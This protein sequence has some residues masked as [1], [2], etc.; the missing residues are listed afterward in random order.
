MSLGLPG[1]LA[2][3]SVA[4]AFARSAHTAAMTCVAMAIVAVLGY[5][6]DEPTM[7][8]WPSI[9]ALLPIIAML[10]V[11]ALTP[12]VLA[13][14]AYLIVGAASLGW[15]AFLIFE[16]FAEADASNQFLITTPKIALV[17]VMGP[18][19]RA[20]GIL[21]WTFAGYAAA[22]LATGLAANAAGVRYEFDGS[23][24]TI[25]VIL[26]IFVA[27]VNVLRDRSRQAQ[28]VLHRAAQE[29]S[30]DVHRSR[31]EVL[32]AA[33][34][35]D[36]V[37]NDLAAIAAS[38]TAP[39][40]PELR[41]QIERDLQTLFGEEWLSDA[42]DS[43]VGGSAAGP[44]DGVFDEARALGLTLIVTG[45]TDAL[46]R[47][48]PEAADALALAVK[49]CLVNVLKHSG[50]TDAE[51]VVL[52]SNDETSVMVIDSGAGFTVGAAD[53]DRFGLRHSVVGRMRAVGGSVQVWSTPGRGTSVM[54][55]VP[56]VA[57]ADAGSLGVTS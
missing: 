36:T 2:P 1:H 8:V 57:T 16:V 11:L 51:V 18:G 37:L 45:A 50:T 15:Y 13:H 34:L 19:V 24:A 23:I 41:S 39:L 9:V 33:L 53:G 43:V 26:L 6:L 12:T 25:F 56:F 31:A 54:I 30:F 38:Q 35:H 21:A 3:R 4:M 28:P 44:L 46:A 52:S 55:R 27:I 48:N 7:I 10:W 49:Q 20:L 22:E 42:P 40:R 29:E 47:I 14:I 32:A 17:L 5:Q